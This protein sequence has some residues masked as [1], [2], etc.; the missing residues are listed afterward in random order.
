MNWCKEEASWLMCSGTSSWITPKYRGNDQNLVH[1]SR[2]EL[3]EERLDLERTNPPIPGGAKT[4]RTRACRRKY[5]KGIQIITN[6]ERI[7]HEELH[8]CI[9]PKRAEIHLRQD[10]LDCGDRLAPQKLQAL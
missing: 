3:L 9:P 6:N 1:R 10:T 7:H 5:P 4:T 8:R 2:D